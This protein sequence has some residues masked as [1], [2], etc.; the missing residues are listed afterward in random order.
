MKQ[1]TESDIRE[2]L[3]DNFKLWN[4]RDRD[5]FTALYR[6]A[7]PNGL[8][9]EYVGQ[10]KVEDGWQAFNYMW[11]NYNHDVQADLREVLV[12]GKEGVCYVHNNSARDGVTHPSIETYLFDKGQLHIRYF[13]NA[14]SLV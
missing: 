14:E 7:S 12:N 1:Y 2:F 11:D 10:E 3:Q 5:A 4:A 6:E 9:I 13:H 8:F